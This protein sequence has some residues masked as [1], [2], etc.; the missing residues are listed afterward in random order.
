MEK[1]IR[2]GILG[3]GNIARKFAMDLALVPEAELVAVASRNEEKAKEFT[4]KGS[5]IYHGNVPE[6][7][8]HDHH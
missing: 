6:C 8:D 4:E 3:L 1:R 2:W 7:A 5:E